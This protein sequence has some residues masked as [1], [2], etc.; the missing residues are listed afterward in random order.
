M[1]ISF[2]GQRF[3][4]PHLLELALTH[5]SAGPPHN[6]RM[7]FLGDA[8]VSAIIAECLYERYPNADEGV[9]T[10]ARSALVCESALAEVARGL[11][12]GERLALGPGELKNGGFRRDS[13]LSDALE[14]VVAAVFLD[15][16]FETCR[17]VVRGWFESRLAAGLPAHQKDAKTR[18]QELLQKQQGSLPIYSVVATSGADHAQQFEVSC[19]IETPE[20]SAAGR[21][22][23]RRQ[24]EQAAAAAL[25]MQLERASPE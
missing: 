10:R 3:T 20:A 22:A 23:S 5:R 12:V 6:E 13:I 25:L 16:G 7:E 15:A 18:L 14:A 17:T 19:R 4:D 24:A 21:G 1:G 8:L 2:C 11:G 9:L